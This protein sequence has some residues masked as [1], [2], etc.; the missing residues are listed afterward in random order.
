M[1]GCTASGNRCR[2]GHLHQEDSQNGYAWL[3]AE[4]ATASTGT[5]VGEGGRQG[6]PMTPAGVGLSVTSG[7]VRSPSTVLGPSARYTGKRIGK[8]VVE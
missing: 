5:G 1:A 2:S 4:H 6:A 8:G 7:V 3:A